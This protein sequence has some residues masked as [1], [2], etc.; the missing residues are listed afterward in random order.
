LST[1][2][3]TV[4]QPD[5]AIPV[6]HFGF[7]VI[8]VPRTKEGALRDAAVRADGHAL[9]IEDE[10]LLPNPGEVSNCEFPRQMNVH[11]WFNDDPLPD[12]GAKQPQNRALNDRGY[13]QS[14]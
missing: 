2:P 7:T 13:R 14:G 11:A 5:R 10:C 4:F 3:S 1:H 6:S 9:K 8:V 12:A